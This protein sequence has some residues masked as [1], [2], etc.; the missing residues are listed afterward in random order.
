MAGERESVWGSAPVETGVTSRAADVPNEPPGPTSVTPSRTPASSLMPPPSGWTDG[1]TDT[2]GP[3]MWDKLLASEQ[4]RN[5][6]HRRTSS[7]VLVDVLGLEDAGEQWGAGLALQ[8]FVQL[9]RELGRGIRRSDYIARIGPARFGILLTETDEISA[10]NFVD[11]IKESCCGNFVPAANGLRLA[12][13]WA[14]PALGGRL[15]DSIRVAEGR[16]QEERN[17]AG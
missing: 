12:V 10:I 11:R 15:A 8:L 13:G 16:L 1:L 3:R 7:V 2:D 4:A 5:A 9:A 6:R 14:S 17:K